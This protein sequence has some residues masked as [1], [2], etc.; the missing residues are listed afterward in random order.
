MIE[1]HFVIYL[2][3]SVNGQP[4]CIFFISSSELKLLIMQEE[5]DNGGTDIN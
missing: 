5:A 3:F 4:L 2:A 1:D